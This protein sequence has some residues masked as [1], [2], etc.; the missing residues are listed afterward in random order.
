MLTIV[1]YLIQWTIKKQ[2]QCCI[3]RYVYNNECLMCTTHMGKEREWEWSFCKSCSAQVLM[4]LS[5]DVSTACNFLA[6]GK[7]HFLKIFR[8]VSFAGW[9]GWWFSVL[10]YCRRRYIGVYTTNTRLSLPT[11]SVG[12]YF[13]FVNILNC[14]YKQLIANN[15]L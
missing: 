4:L 14:G 11:L 8:C 5:I 13:D 7:S 3:I 10:L 1:L 2:P 15:Y 12:E 9:S 6:C